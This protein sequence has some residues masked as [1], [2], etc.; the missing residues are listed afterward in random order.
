MINDNKD[1]NYSLK[2]KN[3][4]SYEEAKTIVETQ[5]PQ[6]KKKSSK[7]YSKSLTP[8]VQTLK[9]I[10]DGLIQAEIAKRLDMNKSHLN[11]Y[12]RRAKQSGFINESPRGTLK[13]LELTQAGK[14]PNLSNNASTCRLENVRVKANVHVMPPPESLDWKRVQMNNW[15]QYSS[16]V[17]SI[18]VHLNDGKNPTVEFIPSPVDGDDPFQLYGMVMYDCTKA[19]ERLEETT[20]IEAGRLKFSSRGEWVEYDPITNGISRHCGQITVDGIGKINASKPS[21]RGALEF[22][23]PKAAADYMAMPI[24]LHNMEVQMHGIKNALN[25]IKELLRRGKAHEQLLD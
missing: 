25:E 16:E 18:K 19:A 3:S 7:F 15:A 23:D 4:V 11:Y 20:G 12:K 22:Y 1:K 8:L 9:L 24:R 6:P 14:R 13:P 21:K 2:H 17:D 10:D 5:A